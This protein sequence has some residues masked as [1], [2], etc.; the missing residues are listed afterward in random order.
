[1]SLASEA[2]ADSP[3]VGRGAPDLTSRGSLGFHHMLPTH[4]ITSASLLGACLH[5]KQCG[6][7]VKL[8]SAVTN[9]PCQPSWHMHTDAVPEQQQHHLQ[10]AMECFAS[11]KATD[12]TIPTSMLL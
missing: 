8:H 6:E 1:M 7:S 5:A 9:V 4:L 2:R 11:Y 3:P 10:S 12:D